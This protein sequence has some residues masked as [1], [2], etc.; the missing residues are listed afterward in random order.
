M[1][2]T[3]TAALALVVAS[4]AVPLQ[5]QFSSLFA[6]LQRCACTVYSIPTRPVSFTTFTTTSSPHSV[7]GRCIYSPLPHTY[8]VPVARFIVDSRSTAPWVGTTDVTVLVLTFTP[9]ERLHG[10]PRT[11]QFPTPPVPVA[12][13]HITPPR[14]LVPLFPPPPVHATLLPGAGFPAPVPVLVLI[15]RYC[16]RCTWFAYY[17]FGPGSPTSARL[18]F[19]LYR[20][21]VPNDGR[22]FGFTAR[23]KT[24]G[25]S[26]LWFGRSTF[27]VR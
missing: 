6:L 26:W 19:S 24:P 15:L 9:T 2:A 18:L 16:A 5:F 11:A 27:L 25:H 3:H 14:V 20:L 17:N 10:A 12:Y 8:N 1:P 21:H 7:P 13:A 22:A 4:P 23:G